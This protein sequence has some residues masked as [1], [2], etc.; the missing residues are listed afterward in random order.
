MPKYFQ[1]IAAMSLNRAIGYRQ[2]LP[3]RLPEELKWFKSKT[4]E[5]V[6]IMGRKTYQSIGKPL[7]RRDNIVI[8]RTGFTAEGVMTRPS[9]KEALIENDHRLYFLI[10]GHQIFTEGL[11]LCSDLYLT[12]VK[13]EVEGDVFFPPFEDSFVAREVVMDNPDF[14]ITHYINTNLLSTP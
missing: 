12:L 4:V 8:S 3:W 5:H 7:P 2:T 13:R 9:L 11:P 6:V 1:A 10:G 14:S